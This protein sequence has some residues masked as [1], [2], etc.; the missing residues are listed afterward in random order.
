M[1]P[2]NITYLIINGNI[3]IRD[4]LHTLK[5]KLQGS[6]ELSSGLLNDLLKSRVHMQDRSTKLFHSYITNNNYMKY[7]YTIN[8]DSG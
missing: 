2:L 4:F 3:F 6:K 5:T 1:T 8:G 7:Q